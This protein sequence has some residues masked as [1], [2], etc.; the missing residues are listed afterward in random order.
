MLMTTV[1]LTIGGKKRR[2]R[3]INIPMKMETK[4]ATSWEPKM[5]EM[6][7]CE[8]MMVKIGI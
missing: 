4:A 5:A 8:P 2:M 7:Y 1:P 3:P 6:P